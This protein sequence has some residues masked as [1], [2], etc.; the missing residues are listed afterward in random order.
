MSVEVS[1]R[2]QRALQH[3]RTG[4]PLRVGLAGS[5][6][7]VERRARKQ[8]HH[9]GRGPCSC[10]A[11]LGILDSGTT[12]RTARWIRSRRLP[13]GT[14]NNFHGGP[15][16]LHTTTE[17]YVALR[18]AGDQPDDAPMQ[19]TAAWIREQGGVGSDSDLHA[20]LAGAERLVVV[21]R[22][23]GHAA[24]GHAAAALVAAQHLRLCLLG[25][26]DHMWR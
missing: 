25:A 20:L 16:D 19:Q 18:L 5:R 1:A 15:S 11:N 14:W 8:R 24:G 17:A 7:L 13:D 10:D 6:G 22:R 12:E 23:T 21:G 4:T 9:R 2:A 26:P 3:H